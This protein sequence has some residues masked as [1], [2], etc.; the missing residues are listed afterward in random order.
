MLDQ[1]GAPQQLP[2]SGSH[3]LSELVSCLPVQKWQTVVLAVPSDEL[4][5]R[6]AIESLQHQLQQTLGAE[7]ARLVPQPIAAA[8]CGIWFVSSPEAASPSLVTQ[9]QTLLVCDI[10]QEESTATLI[11]C[12]PGELPLVVAEQCELSLNGQQVESRLFGALSQ[13]L[14]WAHN[15]TSQGAQERAFL[16]VAE[17]RRTISRNLERAKSGRR[18][19]AAKATWTD[20]GG[21][22]RDVVLSPELYQEA[23]DPL[24]TTAREELSGFLRAQLQRPSSVMVSGVASQTFGIRQRLLEPV[25]SEIYGDEAASGLVNA[26]CF[27]TPYREVASVAGAALLAAGSVT[28]QEQLP[29]DVGA[30]MKVEANGALAHLLQLSP[31]TEE[32]WLYPLLSRG[33]PLPARFRSQELRLFHLLAPG[34][35]LDWHMRW[36]LEGH[37]FHHS[38]SSQEGQDA[39]TPKVI[40]WQLEADS[41]GKVRITFSD[42]ASID[43]ASIDHASIDH[44][45]IDHASIDHASIDHASIDHASLVMPVQEIALFNTTSNS[46]SGA[47]RAVPSVSLARLQ[48]LLASAGNVS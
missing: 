23:L 36:E 20:E 5:D 11:R 25:F 21:I 13:I 16:S 8:L 35:A 10:G 29:C 19:P 37:S 42:H 1:D 47:T 12:G 31:G 24:F 14:G 4:R 45:S 22:E 39:Q 40:E 6:D 34:E 17:L 33:A 38:L 15:S 43:H 41:S 44:A 28:Y 27:S 9:G 32:F 26:P 2:G 48:E 30:R 18:T 7:T 46:V 3:D